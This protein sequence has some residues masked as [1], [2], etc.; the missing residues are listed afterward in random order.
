MKQTYKEIY[1]TI[2]NIVELWKTQLASVYGGELEVDY[3]EG[4]YYA[5][6]FHNDPKKINDVLHD[7]WVE[8]LKEIEC[9][10][11]D[12]AIEYICSKLGIPVC[13]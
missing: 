10:G 3:R 2:K 8:P 6:A 12:S 11:T 4:V 9:L 1:D 5:C 7:N 13:H